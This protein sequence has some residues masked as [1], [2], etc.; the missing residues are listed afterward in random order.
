MKPRASFLVAALLVSPA[1]SNEPA[2]ISPPPPRLAFDLS[3][4][5]VKKAVRD[6]AATQ[7]A[8]LQVA[9]EKPAEQD[10]VARIDFAPPDKPLMAKPRL[11]QATV[12]PPATPPPNEFVTAIVDTLLDL[13][14]GA[15]E[16]EVWH[17]CHPSDGETTMQISVMCPAT[18][19]PP[20]YPKR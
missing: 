19:D 10:P 20:G 2:P 15:P 9:A 8:T 18:S 12:P 7:Y 11:V 6:S 3:N 1:W 4:D 17:A 14:L 16:P 5:S 13:A